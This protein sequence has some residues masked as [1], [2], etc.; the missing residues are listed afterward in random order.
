MRVG[1]PFAPAA[2]WLPTC[3]QMRCILPLFVSSV[4]LSFARVSSTPGSGL[5]TAWMPWQCADRARPEC[6]HHV[7]NDPGSRAA[8]LLHNRGDLPA[9]R[10]SRTA[11]CHGGLL[12][13]QARPQNWHRQASNHLTRKLTQFPPPRHLICHIQ[14][15]PFTSLPKHQ[16]AFNTHVSSI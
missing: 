1:L 2:V 13:R 14:S 9:Q 12:R 4:E 16:G 5:T 6:G 10:A 15:S 7:S 3:D 11:L 8:I